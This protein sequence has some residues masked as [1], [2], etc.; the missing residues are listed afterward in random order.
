[1]TVIQKCVVVGRS[2]FIKNQVILHLMEMGNYSILDISIFQPWDFLWV[3]KVKGNVVS[4]REHRPKSGGVL[5]AL[6]A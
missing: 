4:W 1:M 2:S 5:P 3:H 6:S